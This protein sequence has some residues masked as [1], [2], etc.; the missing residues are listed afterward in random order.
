MNREKY[1]KKFSMFQF[2]IGFSTTNS[3]KLVMNVKGVVSIPYRVQYNCHK[4]TETNY[5]KQTV[6]IPYRVQYN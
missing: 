4:F 1:M 2:L 3:E 6:S 5:S